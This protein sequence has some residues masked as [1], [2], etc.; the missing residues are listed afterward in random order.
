MTADLVDV[1]D[2]WVT[3]GGRVVLEG[4]NLSIRA[5]D[6]LGIIG[7]NGGGK[8]TL[9]KAILGLIQ[10]TQGTITVLGGSPD[11]QRSSLGYVPQ[12]RTFDFGFPISVE[13]VVLMGRLAHI[14]GIVKHY[15]DEDHRV[16]HDALA[17]MEIEDL[18][19]RQIDALSGGQQ[20]RVMLARALAGEPKVLLLDEPTNH[21]DAKSQTRFFELLK[22]LHDKMAVVMVTHDIGAVSTYVDRIACLNHRLFMHD[23]HEITSEVLAE[24]YECPI[25]LIAHGVP[26]RVL[27]VHDHNGGN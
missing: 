11:K 23:S 8:T 16:A 21:V 14:P 5:E 4:I 2:L 26:H 10:P 3:L 13:E 24:I 20:Q 18:T 25:E 19:T 6:F 1:R 9:L 12:Y 15:S 7:P 17:M 22:G 27:Q